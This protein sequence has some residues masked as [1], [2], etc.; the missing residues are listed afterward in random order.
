[1]LVKSWL[2]CVEML[3]PNPKVRR[4]RYN[5]QGGFD[6]AARHWLTLTLA[7]CG[8]VAVTGAEPPPR[9]RRKPSPKPQRRLRAV[10]LMCK[11]RTA[12]GSRHRRGPIL[13]GTPI[14]GSRQG[15][16]STSG[17]RPRARACAE[18]R[19]SR[20][21]P[22]RRARPSSARPE[23]RCAPLFS[24]PILT[25]SK[26]PSGLVRAGTL[27]DPFAFACQ[28]GQIAPCWPSLCCRV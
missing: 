6:V 13:S 25:R 11:R 28:I 23:R 19:Q 1:M 18:G 3:W 21:R 8:A 20:S 14:R 9:R 17:A 15:R 16:L 22:G 7:L 27:R 26:G 4:V 10:A 12:S 5:N 2:N 24:E